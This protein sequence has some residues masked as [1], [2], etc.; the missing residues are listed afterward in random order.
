MLN[1]RVTIKTRRETRAKFDKPL[2]NP[3]AAV[4]LNNNTG[5]KT[6]IPN[7]LRIKCPIK[8][9]RTMCQYNEI[10]M[11]KVL[12]SS[13]EI[14]DEYVMKMA[15]QAEKVAQLEITLRVRQVRNNI[16]D[17]FLQD[18]DSNICQEESDGWRTTY[19]H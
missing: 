19:K 6:F 10:E 18:S 4:G 2:N 5:K 9:S 15:A 7:L 1:L 16:Y 8:R 17:L 12:E 13:T 11:T 14:H 3:P